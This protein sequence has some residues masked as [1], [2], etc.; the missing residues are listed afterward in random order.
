MTQEMRRERASAPVCA[1]VRGLCP[2]RHAIRL[3][4]R[5]VRLQIP[6]DP[7]PHWPV[8]TRLPIGCVE[9]TTT[10]GEVLIGLVTG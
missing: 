9:A 10:T 1:A 7:H 6:K 4:K 8:Y 3:S 2:G 5:R